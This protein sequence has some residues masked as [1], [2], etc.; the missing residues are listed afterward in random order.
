MTRDAI[1]WFEIPAR[2]IVRATRFYE[3]L[4]GTTLRRENMLGSELAVFPSAEDGA[5]GCLMAGGPEP[6]SSTIVYLDAAP[7]LDPALARAVAAGGRVLK[8]KTALPPGMGCFAHIEDSEGNRVG[9]HAP[10]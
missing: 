10:A 7:A 2:D 4:L 9:L 6:G 1:T 8:G 3:T 5:T